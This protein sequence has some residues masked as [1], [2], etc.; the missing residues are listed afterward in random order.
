MPQEPPLPKP[1]KSSPPAEDRSY[2]VAKLRPSPPGN[3]GARF[4]RRK[5]PYCPA[6]EVG[7]PLNGGAP[8]VRQ[9]GSAA[10]GRRHRAIFACSP[11]RVE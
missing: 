2:P 4:P 7:K 9:A 10:K 1:A 8:Q 6:G 11:R 5:A 3:R